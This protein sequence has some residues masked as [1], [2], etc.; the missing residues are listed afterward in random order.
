MLYEHCR[1]P[2]RPHDEIAP[3]IRA[4]LFQ[5]VSSA[6][7][8][9]SAFERAYS[10]ASI[11]RQVPIA[12]L[13]VRTKFKHLNPL[14]SVNSH[15]I[16]RRVNFVGLVGGLVFTVFP[17]LSVIRT[18]KIVENATDYSIQSNTR[19]L[20]YVPVSPAE[21]YSAKNF[22]DTFVVRLGDALAAL[23]IAIASN[24]LLAR[25]GEVG[26][27]ILVGFDLVLG[28]VWL[29][30]AVGIGRAHQ[31]RMADKES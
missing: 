17:R 21:K 31:K 4:D 22:N 30:I 19:E 20:L 8:A 12:A 9:E 13:T 23:S 25:Y 10:G 16:F 29:R 27:K 7:L 1:R 24:V 5:D 11:G 2:Y 18:H 28:L 14:R 6:R 15:S 26:M 3:T